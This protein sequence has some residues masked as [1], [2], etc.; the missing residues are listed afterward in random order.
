ML[1]GR[2]VVI[3]AKKTRWRRPLQSTKLLLLLLHNPYFVILSKKNLV[4][5]IDDMKTQRPLVLER[6]I[7]IFWLVML[8]LLYSKQKKGAIIAVITTPLITLIS[9]Q[10]SRLVIFYE[11]NNWSSKWLLCSRG[12]NSIFVFWLVLH[13]GNTE[14]KSHAL[15]GLW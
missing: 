6:C 2:H 7:T 5:K 14:R 3:A 12:T 11:F 13:H 4:I 8:T 1:H 9:R 15:N 10:W